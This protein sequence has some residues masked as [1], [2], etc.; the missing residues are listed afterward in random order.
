MESRAEQVS[1]ISLS[2]AL[3]GQCLSPDMGTA[4]SRSQEVLPKLTWSIRC[5]SRVLGSRSSSAIWGLVPS[6]PAAGGGASD[7]A[8]RDM[9]A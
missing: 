2:S 9:E 7:S 3:V 5:F 4:G 8:P 6:V 1:I